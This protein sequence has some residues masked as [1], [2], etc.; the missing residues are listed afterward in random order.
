V[1]GGGT[2]Q[3][4]WTSPQSNQYG[5]Y[6][7]KSIGGELERGSSKGN[8]NIQKP[9]GSSGQRHDATGLHDYS[10]QKD[11]GTPTDSPMQPK[12]GRILFQDDLLEN[13]GSSAER[14]S[15]SSGA[16][17]S[18]LRGSASSYQ[19]S[20]KSSTGANRNNAVDAPLIDTSASERRMRDAGR[21]EKIKRQ[22][23]LTSD[24]LAAKER[25][26]PSP[27]K[28]N[29]HNIRGYRPFLEKTKEVPN[30][31]DDIDSESQTSASTRATSIFSGLM[32]KSHT[33][34]ELPQGILGEEGEQ[35]ESDI[36]DDLSTIGAD[37]S[38]SRILRDDDNSPQKMARQSSVQKTP[39]FNNKQRS[40][41]YDRSVGAAA[42]TAEKQHQGDNSMNVVTV[43]NGLVA[44]QSSPEDLDKHR[45]SIQ[46]DG[47]SSDSD[48]DQD[49]HPSSKCGIAKGLSINGA[50]TADVTMGGR[51]F[52]TKTQMSSASSGRIRAKIRLFDNDQLPF[53]SEMATKTGSST[54]SNVLQENLHNEEIETDLSIYSVHPHS[55]RKLVRRFRK[56]CNSSSS[57]DAEEDAKK[58]FALFEMRSRIMESDIERGLERQ[59]GTVPVD[60]LVLTSYNQAACRIRDAVI[61]SKAWR[62]GA[63]PRD[64]IISSLLTRQADRKYVI[65]RL[66][67]RGNGGQNQGGRSSYQGLLRGGGYR[68]YT[69]EEVR[70]M[71]DTDFMQF[72]CPSLG[73]RCMRGFEMFT[74]G[75]CQSILLK[76]T[77]ERCV[78]LRKELNDATARQLD[79]EDL[80]KEDAGSG[81]SII[82]NE[83]G[84]M[85]DAEDLYLTAK[86]EV[87][88]LSKQLVLAERAFQLVRDRIEN[89][90][91]TYQSLLAKIQNESCNDSASEAS[92]DSTY[93]DDD[94][95]SEY[96]E[97]AHDKEKK[98]LARRAQRAE[99]KAEVA[100]REA[101][102][103]KQEA[104]KIKDEKQRELEKLQLKLAELETKSALL[105]EEYGRL[106]AEQK[107]GFGGSIAGS[108]YAQSRAGSDAKSILLSAHSIGKG[109]NESA[110]RIKAKFRSRNMQRMDNTPPKGELERM[111]NCR[112]GEVGRG[113]SERKTSL[114][115]HLLNDEE[116][117]QHLDFYE[118]SLK[119]VESRTQRCQF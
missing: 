95:E 57:K 63:S 109:K 103:A 90:V 114:G 10:G 69:L 116:M 112:D 56:M 96:D 88:S 59:G 37:S 30:L 73:P 93:S 42:T 105:E 118:R 58:S 84:T 50:I 82:F 78:Q 101:I 64:V 60:D 28:L 47:S 46:F 55:V 75:D 65:R 13:D 89:L 39:L 85:A 113:G 6:S 79:A 44:L 48:S 117:Y 99:L 34:R 18:R 8:I 15:S 23:L 71:D 61:V 100:A 22:T 53:S 9:L 119:A 102:L 45:A 31:M 16:G 21:A 20:Q 91:A 2:P 111:D 94:Y 92:F 41:L 107:S 12:T 1:N 33:G 98:I 76:L 110:E 72:R 68:S 81:N 80:M 49:G 106:E 74:I 36:F 25:M 97:E 83:D 19:R 38:F 62:D 43:G 54:V 26:D 108:F 51:E 77:N 35:D 70:W 52:V 3:A 29:A 5:L 67:M 17:L 40:Q 27:P 24:A 7:N 115:R 14:Q 104:E 86:E 32:D 87:K 4:L 11:A 66:V